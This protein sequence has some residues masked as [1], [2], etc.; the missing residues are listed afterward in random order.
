MALSAFHV[1]VFTKGVPEVASVQVWDPPFKV[2]ALEMVRMLF[3]VMPPVEVAVVE[4]ESVRLL[5]VHALDAPR[6]PVPLM[7]TVP[8]VNVAVPAP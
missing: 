1:P 7:V 5:K 2:E 6:N 4:L 8:V 3:M